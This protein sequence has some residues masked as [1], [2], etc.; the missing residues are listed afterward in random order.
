MNLA[1]GIIKNFDS[2]RQKKQFFFSRDQRKD[3]VRSIFHSSHIPTYIGAFMAAN[4]TMVICKFQV[5]Q[6]MSIG[7]SLF[8]E[9]GAK[10]VEN[11]FTKA[12]EK[13]VQIHLP[14]G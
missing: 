3:F 2:N 6:N 14:T 11:L 13:K 4:F 7:N 12:E 1:F 8:D 10:I 5:R 9:E